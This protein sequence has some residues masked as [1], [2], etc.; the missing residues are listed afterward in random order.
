MR[1][2][3]SAPSRARSEWNT[4][5]G[6]PDCP[7]DR[8]RNTG[9]RGGTSPKTH[10]T[11]SSRSPSWRSCWDRRQSRWQRPAYRRAESSSCRAGRAARRFRRCTRGPVCRF[12]IVSYMAPLPE[13]PAMRPPRSTDSWIEYPVGTL[14]CAFGRRCRHGRTLGHGDDT[15]PPGTWPPAS[16][17]TL[18]KMAVD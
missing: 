14:I 17:G 1:R 5:W 3:R 4:R 11:C 16:P 7:A 13:T 2:S 8:S 10:S 6:F 12:T 15:L 18:Q 9:G